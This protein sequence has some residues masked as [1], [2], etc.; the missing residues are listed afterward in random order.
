[1]NQPL[2]LTGMGIVIVGENHNP[3]IL[4]PDFLWRNRIV[5]KDVNLSYDIP[6]ISSPLQSQC[7]FENGLHIVSE[8]NKINFLQDNLKEINSCHETARKY[9]KTVPLVR[10]TAIG[11]NF[12]GLFPVP[13]GN[14]AVRNML[15][16]GEWTQ[17]EDTLPSPKI[18]L[19]Y[20]ID[21]RIVNLTIES[22]APENEGNVLV[23]GNFH[24]NIQ[25]E[26]GESHR[27]AI[28]MVDD[29][30]SDLKRYK[31]LVQTIIGGTKSQ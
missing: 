19:A 15:Q 27:V 31:E 28:T 7:M 2:T 14:Q 17:F 13:D 25:A 6:P 8:S 18:S 20:P 29:W 21:E 3:S 1:M 10:Y 12:T 22:N 4:N 30:E 16:P 9:L 11:I 26:Q 23:R 5:P 24:H